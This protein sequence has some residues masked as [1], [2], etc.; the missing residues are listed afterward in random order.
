MKLSPTGRRLLEAI[1]AIPVIDAHEHLPSEHEY[2]GFQYSGLNLF[3][4]GYIQHDLESAGMSPEFKATMRD[5]GYRPVE[6]WWPQVR[7][8]WRE[9]RHTSYARA[10]R[11]A[12]RDLFGLPDVNDDT[13]DAIAEA[14]REANRPGLYREVL[15]KR[16]GIE[17][18]ITCVD[19]ASFPEDPGLRGITLLHKS[20]GSPPQIA[21]ALSARAGHAVRTLDDAIEAGCTVLRGELAQGALGF[22]MT[23]ADIA[24]PDPGAAERAWKDAMA[25]PGAAVPS[26]AVLDLLYDR[27]F[28]VAA[29]AG[30]PVA[31]HTGYWE[32]FR[33]V[34]PKLMLGFA[35]RRRDVRFDLFHLG[36]PMVRDAIL[37]GKNLPNVTLNLTWCPVVSQL[38]TEQALEEIID[39]VPLTKVIAF[40][41]D[42]RVAV[43][44]VYG[45]L[46]MARE[47]A[48]A[49]LARRVDDGDFDQ[50]EA[51]RIA[52]LWFRENPA[53][54]Y[55]LPRPT[56]SAR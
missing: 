20:T 28:D 25:N 17:V 18:S 24:P 26:R 33:E 9:V 19:R 39:Q 23:V 6:Q 48:A 43:Q 8:Y 29:Q 13:I 50:E 3:A 7:P 32:D 1:S 42:Y 22:K 30:V 55:G 4:G 11:I 14:V 44:K 21:E 56:P 35:L 12:V 49:A 38:Q 40:G 36:V 15:Q 47:A 45:H 34:D 10:L 27:L 46:V 53:R 16:C 51:L 2:L 37:I 52:R 31:V 54:I 5:P 41:G